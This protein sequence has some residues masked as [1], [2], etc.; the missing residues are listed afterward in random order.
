M[1]A[2][3]VP[4]PRGE[5]GDMSSAVDGSSAFWMA[6]EKLLGSTGPPLAGAERGVVAIDGGVSAVL[7][8]CCKDQ[9]GPMQRW[10]PGSV[11]FFFY[12]FTVFP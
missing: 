2:P 11:W 6:G 7:F 1:M 9:R 12:F 5:P 4:L 10:Q 8:F 3:W